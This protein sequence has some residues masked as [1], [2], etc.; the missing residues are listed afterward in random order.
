MESPLSVNQIG[1]D[2]EELIEQERM[3]A[4]TNVIRE[5]LI[6]RNVQEWLELRD[7][8]GSEKASK[9]FALQRKV[10]DRSRANKKASKGFM[11]RMVRVA[12]EIEAGTGFFTTKPKIT[13]SGNLSLK[14]SYDP[15]YA[16]DVCMGPGAFAQYFLHLNPSGSLDGMSLSVERGGYGLELESASKTIKSLNRNQ[17]W[18]KNRARSFGKTPIPSITWTD[19]TLHAGLLPANQQ[20][21]EEAEFSDKA[22]FDAN[23]PIPPQLQGALKAGNRLYDLVI[24]DGHLRAPDQHK[25]RTWD[26][27]RLIISQTIWALTFVKPGGSVLILLHRLEKWNTFITVYRFSKFANVRLFKPK[28]A[29]GTKSSF[30]LVGTNIQPEN[31]VCK[32][33]VEEMRQNW[34][35]MTF[36]GE[37]GFGAEVEAGAGLEV[38]E[39][40]KDWGEAYVELARNIWQIQNE[41]LKEL[42]QK[43]E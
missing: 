8:W 4:K 16:L 32:S 14:A 36:G 27:A 35:T 37:N 30:Y 22:A 40:L 41:A 19:I 26:P 25:G 1:T 17:G 21:P 10:A 28:T 11:F 2:P 9:H 23:P 13:A 42:L 31:E 12:E 3:Y 20:L 39:V 18:Q 15:L 38:E 29:F 24:C 33:W 6:A 7:V 5:F 43:F 34:Y